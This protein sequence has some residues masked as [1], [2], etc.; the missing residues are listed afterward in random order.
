VNRGI[1]FLFL[2]TSNIFS[3]T[4]N[5]LKSNLTD[6][7]LGRYSVG[8]ETKIRDSFSFGLEIDVIN[9]SLSRI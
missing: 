6:V 1:L 3:Q 9:K 7:I 2:I 4:N 5:I 8:L